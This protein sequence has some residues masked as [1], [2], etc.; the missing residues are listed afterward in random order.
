MALEDLEGT[1]KY[2]DALVI[3]NPTDQ[4]KVKF[5]A[6][7]T[8]GIKSVLINTFPKPGGGPRDAP[9]D[10]FLEAHPIGSIYISAGIDP[11]TISGTWT[12]VAEGRFLI[13]VGTLGSDTYTQGAT[14]GSATHVL[15]ESEMPAHT[16]GMRHITGGS[17]SARGL[18]SAASLGLDTGVTES[19]GGGA[20][21]ENRP[22]YIAMDMW[23]RTL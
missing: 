20:A 19:T 11:N 10:V 4:D 9:L 13:G 16:H 12:R 8:R 23:Q 15:T 1:D 2:L 5:Q 7:H 18:A 17:G 3:T 22:P 14:G 21:H 6:A